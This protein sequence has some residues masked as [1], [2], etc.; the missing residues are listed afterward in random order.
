MGLKMP[1]LNVSDP[2]LLV[3]DIFV[4]V[5][6]YFCIF[7]ARYEKLELQRNIQLSL[8]RRLKSIKYQK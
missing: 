8:K 2:L 5:V 6:F 4:F 1:E 7:S 3:L